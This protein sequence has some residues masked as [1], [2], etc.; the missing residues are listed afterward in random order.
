MGNSENGTTAQ[1]VDQDVVNDVINSNR[2]CDLERENDNGEIG[3]SDDQVRPLGRS[4][5]MD[6]SSSSAA[7]AV[8]I[9]K[10]IGELE[11]ENI[12]RSNRE[13]GDQDQKQCLRVS[14]VEMKRSLSCE[15]RFLSSSRPNQRPNSVHLPS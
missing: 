9:A 5:S 13:V 4:V 11:S 10:E 14:H 3:G 12:G 7:A 2:S 1:S 6:S 8:V 15:G